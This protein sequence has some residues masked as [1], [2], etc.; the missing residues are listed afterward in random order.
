M[1]KK[2]TLPLSVNGCNILYSHKVELCAKT[3]AADLAS[4]TRNKVQ[5]LTSLFLNASGH[6]GIH[7]KSQAT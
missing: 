5:L 1:M 3:W 7:V 4:L 2:T 6:G